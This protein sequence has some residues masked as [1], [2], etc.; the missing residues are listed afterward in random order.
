MVFKIFYSIMHKI[1]KFLLEI[2][3]EMED[4]EGT[5]ID[6]A[7]VVLFAIEEKKEI[8][9]K[10]THLYEDYGLIDNNIVFKLDCYSGIETAKVGDEIVALC[11]KKH[12][13]EMWKAL[14]VFKRKTCWDQS[15][16]ESEVEDDENLWKDKRRER[17]ENLMML[18]EKLKAKKNEEIKEMEALLKEKLGV[19]VE[20]GDYGKLN[21]G[22]CKLLKIIVRY[23]PKLFYKHVIMINFKTNFF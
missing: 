3:E 2:G 8:E 9:G 6:N 17:F 16:D 10:I 22:D 19:E 5:D 15:S 1:V 14:R 23:I 4:F 20:G 12:R 13:N 7:N 11:S 18:K 21:L